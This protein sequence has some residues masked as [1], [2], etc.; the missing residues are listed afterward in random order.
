VGIIVD[1]GKSV[2][3][4][5][6]SNNLINN[7]VKDN[8]I[9]QRVDGMVVYSVFRRVRSNTSTG[10][11]NPLIHAL[12]SARGYSIDLPNIL[13]FL[14]EFYAVVEKVSHHCQADHVIPVP[15]RSKVAE[16]FAKRISRHTSSEFHKAVLQ[17]KTHRDICIDIDLL[18]R[19]GNLHRVEEKLLGDVRRQIARSPSAYFEMKLVDQRFRKYFSPFKTKNPVSVPAGSSVL[20]VDDLLSTGTSLRCAKDL[21]AHHGVTDVKFLCLLGSTGPFTKVKRPANI[22]LND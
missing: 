2:I 6:Q 5:G 15:S 3:Y 8:P 13:S 18:I 7:C 11:G 9:M 4:D 1:A 21:L 14:P 12:K 17:K 10:D 19:S 20:L 22:R 16:M